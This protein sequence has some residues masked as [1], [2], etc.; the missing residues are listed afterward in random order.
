MEKF[1]E[2]DIEWLLNLHKNGDKSYPVRSKQKKKNRSWKRWAL[3]ISLGFSALLF[4]V[5]FPFFLLIRFSVYLNL[6]QGLGAWSSLTGGILAT[7]ILLCFYL[8]LLSFKV[9]NIKLMLKLGGIGV[10]TMVLGFSL[11][12]LFYISSMNAKSADV[13]SVYRSMHPILRVAVSTVTLAESDLVITDIERF[14]E[15]YAGMGLPV[16]RRS[17]HYRQDSGYVHAVD[18][19]TIGHGILRN[20]LLRGSLE[21]MGFRTIRHVGTAD[22]LHVELRN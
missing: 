10:S 5:I 1:S 22:H 17:L 12:S 6:T 8:L 11:F 21:L 7:I 4:L 15:D 14:E 20:A 9:S 3:L 2:R 18:I 19:R 16:N 13:Q